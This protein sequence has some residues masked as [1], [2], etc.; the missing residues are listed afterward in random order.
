RTVSVA[1]STWEVLQSHRKDQTEEMMLAGRG[2]DRQD[3]V[4]AT[5]LGRI[6]DRTNVAQ[7]WKTA[8]KKAGITT[9]ARFYD[10]RHSH[11]TTL[12]NNGMDIAL[13]PKRRG[14]K[15]VQ[16]TRS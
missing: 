8:L 5:R 14:P 4:F 7:R 10:T 2:Y 3:F 1:K 15:S 11:A 16:T 12:L 13:V 9:K 6:L